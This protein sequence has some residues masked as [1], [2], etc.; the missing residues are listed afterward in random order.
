MNKPLTVMSCMPR[1]LR[2]F[3]RTTNVNNFAKR[4]TK[5]R[6]THYFCKW[7]QKILCVACSGAPARSPPPPSQTF[8]GRVHNAPAPAF[9][10]PSAPCCRWRR[11]P[12]HNFC[13]PRRS[14]A[15]QAHWALRPA[16]CWW[17]ALGYWVYY[18]GALAGL[19][20]SGLEII[21]IIRR[22]QLVSHWVSLLGQS[23]D[24]S[25]CI[26][27]LVGPGLGGGREGQGGHA[28]QMG[29]LHG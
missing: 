28:T 20:V 16:H 9:A 2:H 26:V 11:G 18:V 4:C 27:L 17:G 7:L 8:P 24:H 13:R 1:P 5:N 15:C 22:Q 14:C 12:R 23:R 3:A 10:C 6:F 19:G 29:M 25:Q 21:R